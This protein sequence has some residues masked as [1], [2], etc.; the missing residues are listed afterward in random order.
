MR[1]QNGCHGGLLGRLDLDIPAVVGYPACDEV[2]VIGCDR[3]L[4]WKEFARRRTYSF[5]KASVNMVFLT[6][7]VRMRLD[8][9]ETQ[10]TFA[11]T[12]ETY[13]L[14]LECW[15]G[16]LEKARVLDRGIINH[17]QNISPDTRKGMDGLLTLV[18]N[19]SIEYKDLGNHLYGTKT[20]LPLI[21]SKT[22]L[23][24]GEN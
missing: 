3:T 11:R 18:D 15:K 24:I 9:P 2:I 5:V 17:N 10:N 14:R 21:R 1:A 19:V 12:N 4:A 8:R 20:V 6:M 7:L 16:G 13:L 22:G 23:G